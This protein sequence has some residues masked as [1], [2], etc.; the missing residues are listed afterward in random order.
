MSTDPTLTDRQRFWLEHLRACGDGS[1]KAYAEAHE[2][3]LRALYDAK[4]RLKRKGALSSLAPRLVRAERV[5]GE[6]ATAGYC[7]VHLRN[8]AVVDVACAPG[9]WGEL[10]ASVAALP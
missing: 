5:R 2:L 7:R 3:D 8:G 10:L 6:N 1:L 9:H 4:A